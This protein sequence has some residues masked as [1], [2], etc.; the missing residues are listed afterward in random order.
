MKEPESVSPGSIMPKYI[1][2]YS[3][4]Y[5]I[6]LLSKKIEVMKMLGVPYPKNYEN[7]ALQ[8]LKAQAEF[9]TQDL[10]SAGFDANSEK[11]IIALI[12][13]LQRLGTDIKVK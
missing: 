9:I 1:W 10:K 8:D 6:S 11:E 12:A 2:L 4:N 5:D 13:Y 7:R 3:D